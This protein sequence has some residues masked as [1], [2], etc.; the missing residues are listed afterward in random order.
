MLPLDGFIVWLHCLHIS[1]ANKTNNRPWEEHLAMNDLF[2]QGPSICDVK[3]QKQ[4]RKHHPSL[5]G[6]Q[7][8]IE[9]VN[10]V[11]ILVFGNTIFAQRKY[12]SRT[13]ISQEYH[14]EQNTAAIYMLSWIWRCKIDY[15]P[16][17]SR[18]T[19]E[20][21]EY[22]YLPTMIWFAIKKIRT[23]RLCLIFKATYAISS[24]PI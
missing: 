22:K 3:Q 24:F 12:F 2:L 8:T 21:K 10:G 14:N 4:L 11:H 9:T 23:Y 5:A 16:P 6:D 13:L 15:E 1:P 17:S 18:T 19:S 7:V 20:A